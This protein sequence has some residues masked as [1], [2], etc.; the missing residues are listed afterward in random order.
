MPL[1]TSVQQANEQILSTDGTTGTIT[2]DAVVVANTVISYSTRNADSQDRMLRHVFRFVLTNT[3]TITWTRASSGSAKEVNMEWVAVEYDSGDIDQ[4]EAGT[5]D[6]DQTPETVTLGTAVTEARAVC[7]DFW[8]TSINFP[9]ETVGRNMIGNSGADLVFTFAVAPVA[10]EHFSTYQ[11]VEFAT[12]TV[13]VQSGF[14]ALSTSE[15]SDTAALTAVD[16]GKTGLYYGGQASSQ[17]SSSMQRNHV[18]SHFAST[19]TIQATRTLNGTTQAM[20]ISYYAC[21][22]LDD[23]VVESGLITIADTATAPTQ[24]TFTALDTAT[25]VPLVSNTYSNVYTDDST[26]DMED[27]YYS[28]NLSATAVGVDVVRTGTDGEVFCSWFVQEFAGSTAAAHTSTGSL[29]FGGATILSDGDANEGSAS[30]DVGALT[31][32]ATG[33][34]DHEGTASLDLGILSLA[35]TGNQ[36]TPTGTGD[37]IVGGISIAASALQDH[38][39][40]ATLN[41]GVLTIT[42]VGEHAHEGTGSLDLAAISMAATGE[43]AHEGTGSLDVAPISMA[44][45]GLQDTPTGTGSLDIGALTLA[46]T[47]SHDHEG[48]GDLALGGVAIAGSGIQDDPGTGSLDVA[49]MTLAGTGEHAHEGTGSLVVGVITLAASAIHSNGHVGSAALDLAGLSISGTAEQQHQGSGDLVL[50][51]VSLAATGSHDHG[52]TGS[53]VFDGL[54]AAAIGALPSVET[55]SVEEGYINELISTLVQNL[56]YNNEAGASGTFMAGR[57][58]NE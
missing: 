12:G 23:D 47:G 14:V 56:V 40:T 11:V 15:G 51:T 21:E 26:S 20:D 13:A 2:I 52:G 58:K 10:G 9:G 35:A 49:A 38:Q 17:A 27:L 3:T 32:A 1:A 8:S 19:T 4:I 36:A 22:S 29:S 44:G 18:R 53:L 31:L 33:S 30:L 7:L 57:G 39:G 6:C 37:L 24:P 45:T 42:A 48:T 25:S 54:L 50:G 43:H 28:L 16:L 46:A 55:G 5:I 34:H 41:L